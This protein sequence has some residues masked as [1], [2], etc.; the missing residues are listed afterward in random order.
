MALSGISQNAKA[1]QEFVPIKE[2]RD[3][4]VVL[5][6]G[7]MRSILMTSSINFALKSEDEQTAILLQFQSFL[8]SLE[9]S[10]QIFIQ[11]RDLDIR[12]YTAFLE[13][14][15]REQTTELMRI[16]TR[17]YIEFVKNFTEGSNIM[18]KHFFIVIPYS[19]AIVQRQKTMLP[20]FLGGSKGSKVKRDDNTSFEENRSQIE[21]R[22]SVI[23]QGLA[24]V[25][26][27]IV[28]LGTEEIIEL[29]YRLFNPGELS[30][31]IPMDTQQ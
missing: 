22:V 26:V 9:F 13:E 29:F 3:G 25:G 30:K 18:S 16:Q 1:T 31:P 11:S 27:R 24:R 12:P 7:S 28:N 19:G 6:D 20:G 23:E 14:R 21:Q 10:I 17:E 8:N 2:V 4:I 5:K 15:Y